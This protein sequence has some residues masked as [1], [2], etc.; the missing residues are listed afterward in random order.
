M[1]IYV[2][3]LKRR[4]DRLAQMDT[5]LAALGLPY[6][7]IDAVD[8][9]NSNIGQ[10]AGHK[11]PA[12][13]FACY[14]SHLK[15]YRAFVATGDSHCVI[16]EDDVAL[17]PRLP[18]ALSNS[19]FYGDQ[20]AIVRLEAPTNIHWHEPSF[21]APKAVQQQTGLA[22]YTL[23]SKSYGTGAFVLPRSLA[24]AITLIESTNKKHPPIDYSVL[25]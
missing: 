10:P 23:K 6:T 13:A 15:A 14:L 11:L 18:Q 3:N 19:L 2:I 9:A 21:N 7:H 22:T 5:A 25:R 8:G 20:N 1:Q 24:K 12:S 4:P 17:S 16:M